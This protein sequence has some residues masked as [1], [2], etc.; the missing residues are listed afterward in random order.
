MMANN[1]V[2]VVSSAV[3]SGNYVKVGRLLDPVRVSILS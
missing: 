3:S 1:V 2:R